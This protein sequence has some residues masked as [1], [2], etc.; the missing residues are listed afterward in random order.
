VLLYKD[1][2]V[3]AR[4][5]DAQIA[6]L[7]GDLTGKKTVLV[8]WNILAAKLAVLLAERGASIVLTAAPAN[9]LDQAVAALK[10]LPLAGPVT[11][12]FEASLDSAAVAAGAL[13]LIGCTPQTPL[14]SEEMV[15]ALDPGGIV[16]DVGVGTLSPK[17]AEQGHR[18][19]LR[20]IRVDMRAALAGEITGLLATRDMLDR[21]MGRGEI[22]GQRVVAGG[23]I[24]DNGEIVVDSI[25]RP[26][27]V[28][29]VADGRGFLVPEPD[30]KMKERL[31]AVEAQLLRNLLEG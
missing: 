5:A 31:R 17:A 30:A 22:A 21:G 3:W 10:A 23:V 28:L 2:D 1:T 13:V 20:L 18:R 19:G 16:F 29:G 14:I 11:P 9:V 24:G 8:G 4:A 15:Q 26:S 25:Q 27:C 7:A 12:S 6:G